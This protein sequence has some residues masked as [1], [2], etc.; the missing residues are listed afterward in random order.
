MLIR[1]KEKIKKETFNSSI[2]LHIRILHE[3]GI[4]SISISNLKHHIIIPKW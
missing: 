2:L 1:F 3:L 4:I